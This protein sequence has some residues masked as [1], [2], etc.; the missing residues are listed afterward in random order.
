MLLSEGDNI[1][2]ME[3]GGGL[4]DE[5]GALNE[6]FVQRLRDDEAFRVDFVARTFTRDFSD[7]SHVIPDSILR[8]YMF[9]QFD[10]ENV[11]VRGPYQNDLGFDL[12]RRVSADRGPADASALGRPAGVSQPTT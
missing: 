10:V 9:L 3:D 8:R 12:D 2:A 6:A 5:T 11:V 4:V 7:S 1:F